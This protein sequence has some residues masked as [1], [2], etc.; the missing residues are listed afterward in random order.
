M[1]SELQMLGV[2]EGVEAQVPLGQGPQ[3]VNQP[4]GLRHGFGFAR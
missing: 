2:V 3:I 1:C 4:F